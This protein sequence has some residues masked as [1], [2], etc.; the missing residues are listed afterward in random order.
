MYIHGV[1][2]K[3]SNYRK[4]FK[5]EREVMEHFTLRYG[6]ICIRSAGSHGSIDVIAGNGKEVYAIQVKVGERKRS[7][8]GLMLRLDAMQFKAIP[9]YAHK[10][11]YKGWK[12]DVVTHEGTL[13]P[14]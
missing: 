1:S 2:L 7:F 5:A 12:Y 13:I 8:S 6:C 3:M 11:L 4:G 10:Q 9:V 14:L